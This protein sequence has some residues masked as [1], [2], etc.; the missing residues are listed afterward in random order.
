MD[1]LFPDLLLLSFRCF[2]R[3][4]A[5]GGHKRFEPS[6]QLG[7]EPAV[8]TKSDC[9][10][11]GTRS[12]LPQEMFRQ[13]GQRKCETNAGNNET[14]HPVFFYSYL[15]LRQRESGVIEDRLEHLRSG[16]KPNGFC[17][18]NEQ[19]KTSVYNFANYAKDCLPAKDLKQANLLNSVI[20]S[21]DD[22]FCF[23]DGDRLLSESLQN[24]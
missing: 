15:L 21:V 12:Q 20:K 9:E 16:Y 18:V 23:K 22:F 6:H 17:T 14:F 4:G 5:R 1:I 7:T 10:P 2:M 24:Q 13:R 19:I 11:R 3:C 8:A